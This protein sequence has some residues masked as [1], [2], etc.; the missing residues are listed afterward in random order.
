MSIEIYCLLFFYCSSI[1]QLLWSS[2]Y[3][4]V[5]MCV[6]YLVCIFEGKKTETRKTRMEKVIKNLKMENRF[7]FFLMLLYLVH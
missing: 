4:T 1:P 7:C 6:L 3:K 2:G 5:I